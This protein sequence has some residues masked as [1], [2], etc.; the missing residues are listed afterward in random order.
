MK[1]TTINNLQQSS[2]VVERDKF[3]LGEQQPARENQVL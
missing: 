3:V 1:L 2:V